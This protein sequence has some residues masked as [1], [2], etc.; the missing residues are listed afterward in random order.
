MD[1]LAEAAERFGLG[2]IDQISFVVADLE[3]AIDRYQVLFGP[4]WTTT[5]T[6][7]VTYRHQPSS[8][9]LNLGFGKSGPLEVELVQ[10]VEGESPS[11]DYLAAHGEG[12][13]H[14]RFPV[15][16]LKA[17]Q[18]AMEQQNFVTTF[19]G[20]EG[21]VLFAYLDPPDLGTTFL[22]LI[23]MPPTS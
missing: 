16:D 6:M 17:T 13:H 8:V 19:E 22:E 10:V 18:A 23:Q 5:V 1:T 15:D 9:T 21:G 4:F 20:G 2:A 11:A 7:N 14:V 3:E 12:L